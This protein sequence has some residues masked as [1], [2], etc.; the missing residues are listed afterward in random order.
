MTT[1]DCR[2]LVTKSLG[3]KL[4][5]EVDEAVIDYI[6]SILSEDAQ[7]FVNDP[8]ALQE[9]VAPLLESFIPKQKELDAVCQQM[10]RLVI[11]QFGTNKSK[12][13]ASMQAEKLEKAVRIG[14]Q[15]IRDTHSILHKAVSGEWKP[16]SIQHKMSDQERR[17]IDE[18]DRQ[19]RERRDK[20]EEEKRKT[21]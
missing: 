15:E 5:K 6:V 4:A 1:I 21:E 7:S 20:K 12:S 11:E 2:T 8:S 14:D 19:K 16:D 10:Q 18:R 17:A 9:T 3:A 13:S